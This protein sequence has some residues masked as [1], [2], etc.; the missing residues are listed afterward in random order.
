MYTNDPKESHPCS[1]RKDDIVSLVV[2]RGG[3]LSDAKETVQ[4]LTSTSPTA[5]RFARMVFSEAWY[6]FH[7]FVGC[8]RSYL[9]AILNMDTF[10][11]SLGPYSKGGLNLI[12]NIE[13]HR[14]LSEQTSTE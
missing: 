3:S 2:H 7:Q 5:A 12:S 14:D 11:C 10:L 8:A 4:S 13:V 9:L 1:L 6:P